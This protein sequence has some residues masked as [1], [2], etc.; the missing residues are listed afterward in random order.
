MLFSIESQLQHVSTLF[1]FHF[2]LKLTFQIKMAKH[3]VLIQ[4]RTHWIDDSIS[5]PIIYSSSITNGLIFT[6]DL[7]FHPLFLLER[8]SHCNVVFT[9]SAPQSASA[10]EVSISFPVGG[11]SRDN[12]SALILHAYHLL[13]AKFS[14]VNVE[15][16][17]NPLLK[18]FAPWTWIRLSTIVHQR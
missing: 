17:R 3:C 12:V 11:K 15:F 14:T 5:N 8:S 7:V 4:H 10:P 2:F 6:F 1:W 18:Y 9:Q 13:P 16:S